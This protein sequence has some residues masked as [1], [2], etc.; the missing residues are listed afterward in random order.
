MQWEDFNKQFKNSLRF[1]FESEM[2]VLSQAFRKS[3]HWFVGTSSL[4]FE[5]IFIVVFELDK[6]QS[7]IILISNAENRALVLSNWTL[8]VM[9][10]L[11]LYDII[12]YEV[13]TTRHLPTK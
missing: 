12:L 5:F 13:A 11:I 4:P 8:L 3:E 2:F 7:E 1:L 6:W 9:I 10:V